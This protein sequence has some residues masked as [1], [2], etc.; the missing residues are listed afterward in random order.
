MEGAWLGPRQVEPI[1]YLDVNL[2]IQTKYK[3]DNWSKMNIK[4]NPFFQ[5]GISDKALQ[6]FHI[7]LY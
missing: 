3:L 1:Q 7:L 6:F 2:A 4:T 5:K